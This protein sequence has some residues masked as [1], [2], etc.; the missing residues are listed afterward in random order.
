M[1]KYVVYIHWSQTESDYIL[2]RAANKEAAKE[3]VLEKYKGIW[4]VGVHEISGE[5]K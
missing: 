3:K 1:N 4:I 2:V 5:I